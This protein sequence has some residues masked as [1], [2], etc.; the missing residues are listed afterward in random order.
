MVRWVIKGSGLGTDFEAGG[1]SGFLVRVELCTTPLSTTCPTAFFP[2]WYHST[3]M[4]KTMGLCAYGLAHCTLVQ[5]QTLKSGESSWRPFHANPYT[6]ATW[7]WARNDTT[8]NEILAAFITHWHA[9]WAYEGF[10]TSMDL[11]DDAWSISTI[12]SSFTNSHR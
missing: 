12:L 5:L 6:W 11:S 1:F 9:L 4:F 3:T 2:A 8:L 7:D 10:G